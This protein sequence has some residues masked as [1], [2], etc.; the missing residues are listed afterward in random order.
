MP[1]DNSLSPDEVAQILDYLN[2]LKSENE[3]LCE[4]VLKYIGLPKDLEA[5]IEKSVELHKAIR[6]RVM[7]F[8]ERDGKLGLVPAKALHD[9]TLVLEVQ[10]A[11]Y[12]KLIKAAWSLTCREIGK[13]N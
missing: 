1:T 8:V 4:H 3:K 9:Y 7:A 12:H 6:H 2:I 5:P 11:R 13:L 10:N